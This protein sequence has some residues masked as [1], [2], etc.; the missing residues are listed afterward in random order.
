MR[1]EDASD[2]D[3]FTRVLK[4]EL[5]ADL[6]INAP[7]G[8]NSQINLARYSPDNDLIAG[9]S[10]TTS[11]GWLRVNML[12]VA[13][14]HRGTG[15]GRQIMEKAFEQSVARACHSVWLE[16]SSQTACAFYTALGFEEFGALT[17]PSNAP[18]SSHQRWFLRRALF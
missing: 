8:I 9:L 16:T 3:G 7:Q 14:P 2:Q 1:F 4:Q 18:C 13:S 17:N 12:W 15:I 6:R 10:G 11:Y 5:L